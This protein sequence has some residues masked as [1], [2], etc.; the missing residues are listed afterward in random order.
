M[1]DGAACGCLRLHLPTTQNGFP[2]R[3]VTTGGHLG[4]G[5]QRGPTCVGACCEGPRRQGVRG[6]CSEEPGSR[7]LTFPG[8]ETFAITLSVRVRPTA[9]WFGHS[10][11]WQQRCRQCWQE[12]FL[13]GDVPACPAKRAARGERVLASIAAEG[14]A[15]TRAPRGHAGTSP[16]RGAHSRV[17]ALAAGDNLV[18]KPG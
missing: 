16:A 15:S 2:A 17:E 5:G 6:P 9:P 1:I 12:A 3:L 10:H 8:N 4:G 18:L 7:R 13:R 11:T 14:Q